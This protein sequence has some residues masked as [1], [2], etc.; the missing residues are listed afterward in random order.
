MQG[1]VDP[2]RDRFRAFAGLD[3]EGP[4]HMLNL[5]RLRDRAVYDDGR[6]A[7]GRE[8]YTPTAV[9]PPASSRARAGSSCGAGFRRRW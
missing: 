6:E 5:L 9:K 7:T 8:A 2:D 1:F 4:V 3:L